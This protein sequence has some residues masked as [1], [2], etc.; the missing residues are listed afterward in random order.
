MS[1][2]SRS[3][4]LEVLREVLELLRQPDTDITWTTYETPQEAV[5]DMEGHVRRIEANDLSQLRPLERLFGPN[6]PLREIAESNGWTKRYLALG[7]RLDC[8]LL[9]DEEA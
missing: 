6:G 3:Q 7:H 1:P 2:E 8:C 4:L 5:A 9:A